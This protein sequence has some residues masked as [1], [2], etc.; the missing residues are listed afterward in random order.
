MALLLLFG[1]M[2]FPILAQDVIASVPQT[3]QMLDYLAT[4]YAG[5]VKDGAVISA[6]EYAEMR[7]FTSTARSRIGALPSTATTPALMKQADKLVASVD[8]KAAPAQVATQAHALADA[9]LQAY[10][11]PT[12]PEHVPDLVRGE[13]LYQNQ[14]AAC[15]GVT[16]HGDGPAG[17]QLS[18][19][20][21]NFTDQTRADQR[22]A[23]SLYEV[24]SQGVEG[25]PMVSYEQQLSSDDRWALAYYVG[26]LAYT[27][28]ASTGA[29]MWQHDTAAQAQVADLKELSRARVTQLTPT[30]DAARARAILGYLRAHP[31]AIQ[32]QALAGIPLA[33]ARLTASLTAYR[34]GAK[35]Q[36]T[37]LALSAYL[38]GVEPV[39]P[40]LNARDGALRAQLETAMGAYRTALTSSTSVASV[41][42]HADEVDG[43]LLRAQEVTA[44]AAGDAATT[45]LGAFT[46][47]VREGLEALLVVVALLAFLRKA[48]RPEALRYVHAGWS[49]ALV[50]GG[51]TWAI[52]SYAISISGAGR[53]LTEGLSSLFAA[54][55]LLGVGL[56]MHQK[57]IGGRW[58][59]Y[60][61][62]K[63]A[64]ALNRRS[65]W[66]LFG[67]AFISVYREVF[68][69]ILFYAALWNDGQEVW[70]LGGIAAGA[71]V[72]GLIAWVLLRTSRRLPIGTFFSA[73]SALIAVLAVVL[74]GKGVAALQEAGWVAVSVAP[75]PHIEL[76]GIYPTW[77]SLL[78][79][80]AIL[81]LLAV[82]FVFNIHRGRQPMPSSPTTRE[83][84]PDVD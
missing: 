33:R 18:P 49:L 60:L 65:A 83:V 36:A 40:Q 46:I 54:F 35:A 26:S 5:A 9:L 38:D 78:A 81:I 75:V 50:A 15:H 41:S 4:D 47:L 72:L 31:E 44:D 7:E 61:K 56:W 52:A 70:L 80:L 14:C 30:L 8:A 6:S 57:S 2:A 45:F 10:P 22:S 55:V 23:L 37:Q 43:L 29:D 20:P 67:L 73:S 58:Q 48:A 59:A 53:E 3:W 82:G 84:L 68:E 27:K 69:S 34:A 32:Q 64:A 66:F 21:V 42:K 39:E 62:E 63:M 13:A 71:A 28:E 76:L 74:T 79:Q 16:G 51:I 25:T 11:V 24:I 17:M 77:Q 19:R 1:T 12:A